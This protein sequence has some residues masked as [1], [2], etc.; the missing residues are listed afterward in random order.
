MILDTITWTVTA[1]GAA[2][3][4]AVP[5]TG[6]SAVVRSADDPMSGI[7]LGLWCK[8][9]AAGF[10]RLTSPFLHDN[11]RGIDIRNIANSPVNALPFNP[12][13]RLKAN[14]LLTVTQAGS[15]VAGDVELIQAQI[16]Y[17][18]IGGGS[19]K[20]ITAEE[21]DAR[22][23]ALVTDDDTTTATVASTYSG[24]RALNQVVTSLKANRDYAVLGAFI[25]VACASI[26]IRG[27]DTGNIRCAIPGNATLL[28]T[29]KQH[30][31][32]MAAWT[33]L[34]VIPVIN[35]TNAGGTFI[36]VMQDENLTA[37]PFSLLLALL[38]PK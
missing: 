29:T 34:D 1:P 6:D 38:A 28:G 31:Y 11:V 12:M 3:V 35:A 19:S 13:Q 2:G 23:E 37:V 10:T 36:E 14:D 8:A 17:P 5:V 26:S 27:Q 22:I 15:A 33:G 16:A 32:E 9:Q 7:L 20:Y 24:A 18:N 4:A 21:V 30:F 25:G